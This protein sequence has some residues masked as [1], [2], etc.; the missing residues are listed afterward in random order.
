MEW[1]ERIDRECC[2]G[3]LLDSVV[4]SEEKRERER[5]KEEVYCRCFI[6]KGIKLRGTQGTRRQE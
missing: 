1:G 6:W 3:L 2:Q 4:I 5:N